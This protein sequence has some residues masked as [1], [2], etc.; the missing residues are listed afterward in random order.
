MTDRQSGFSSFPEVSA[1][2]RMAYRGRL[3]LHLLG[4]DPNRE[5]YL[6]SGLDGVHRRSMPLMLSAFSWIIEVRGK[7]LVAFPL[8]VIGMNSLA[9]YL[10]GKRVTFPSGMVAALC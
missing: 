10:M 6:A 4:I 9:A 2:C 8:V 7:R 1:Q 3:L 5:A